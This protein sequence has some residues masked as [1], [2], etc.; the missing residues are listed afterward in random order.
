MMSRVSEKVQEWLGWCPMAAAAQ[1]VPA[2]KTP[3]AHPPERATDA[4]PVAKRALLFSRLTF[5][6][7][8]LSWI[9]ALAALPY[10]PETIPVHWNIYGEADGFS[11]RLTGAFSIPALI[12]LTTALLV[13][14]PRFD[15]MRE[16]FEDS[17]DIYAMVTFS[18]VSLILGIQSIAMLSSAGMNVPVAVAFPILLGFF[19]IVIGSLMPYVRRNTTIGFRLPWTIRNEAVWKRTHEH[20]GTV[21]LLAGVLMVIISAGA[22]AHAAPFAVGIL[23]ASVLYVAVWSYRLSRA[24]V[25]DEEHSCR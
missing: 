16:T 8:G 2:G 9:V 14:L 23:L 11:G 13:V 25:V 19:F 4:G 18:T 6:V 1:Q 22:G 12:T 3:E 24:G 21:F 7:V 17:R 5:A 15:R 20:G 10:L